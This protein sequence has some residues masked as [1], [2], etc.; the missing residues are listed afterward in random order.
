MAG[1]GAHARGGAHGIFHL[2]LQPG[3]LIFHLHLQPGILM[4]HARGGAHGIFHL[5]LQPGILIFHLHLQ[6]G[7]L[8]DEAVVAPQS[9][10]RY[11][12]L[13]YINISTK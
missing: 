9:R 3:I 6:P 13:I 7:I 8:V 4:F 11:V 2:H 12:M 1:S 10:Q 5:H